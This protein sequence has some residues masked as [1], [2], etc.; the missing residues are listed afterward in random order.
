MR[1]TQQSASKILLVMS[2]F[3]LVIASACSSNQVSGNEQSRSVESPL[4]AKVAYA[5][6]QASEVQSEAAPAANPLVGQ[7]AL[8][9]SKVVE[10]SVP[11]QLPAVAAAPAVVEAVPPPADRAATAVVEQAVDSEPA[12]A[13]APA[14]ALPEIKPQI[15]FIAPDF[16]LQTLDGQV[17]QLAE[18][19]GKPV[20]ISYWATWCIPCKQ[21]LPILE[22]LSQEYQ[23]QGVQFL[24]I[25][26][27]E[28]DNLD[29][30]KQYLSESGFTLPVLLD[31]DNQFHNAYGQL[32]FPTSYYI[33][34]N[35]IIQ[36]MKLGDAT[37][38]DIRAKIGKLLSGL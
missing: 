29:Q 1:N 16:T 5:A 13:N 28:Q 26:A 4:A 36:D 22:R 25:N 33:D 27:I 7:P 20:V 38:T 10:S 8:A 37:E 14:L 19:R 32:F 24:L 6:G 3:V 2:V 23:A 34:V 30:V 18:L 15:G 9:Q 31:Q 17:V 21:E 12:A 11:A 35:G